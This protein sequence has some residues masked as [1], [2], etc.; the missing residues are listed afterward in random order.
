[1]AFDPTDEPCNVCGRE[2]DE[3][4]CDLAPDLSVLEEEF[5]DSEEDFYATHYLPEEEED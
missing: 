5:P 2:L 4:V 1:M 3:C